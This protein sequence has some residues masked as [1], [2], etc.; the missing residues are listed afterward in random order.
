[1]TDNLTEDDWELL[2]F[3]QACKAAKEDQDNQDDQDDTLL[4]I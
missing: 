4:L 3:D 1:M 2:W